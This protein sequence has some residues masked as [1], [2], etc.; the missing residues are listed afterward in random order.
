M[1]DSDIH[2]TGKLEFG[3]GENLSK[4]AHISNESIYFGVGEIT[5]G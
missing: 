4:T 1:L 2:Y 3:L 5:W